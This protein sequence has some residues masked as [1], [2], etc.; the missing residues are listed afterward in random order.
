MNLKR[1]I[2]LLIYFIWINSNAQTKIHK[3]YYSTF[4]SDSI[5]VTVWLPDGYTPTQK[6]PVFYEF[7]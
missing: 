3:K 2:T 4:A 6:Y 1:C 7:V 5:A